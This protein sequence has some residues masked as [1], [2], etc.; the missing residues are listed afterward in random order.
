MGKASA[1]PLGSSS[2][3]ERERDVHQD[4]DVVWTGESLALNRNQ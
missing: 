4:P 2:L 3:G 1:L